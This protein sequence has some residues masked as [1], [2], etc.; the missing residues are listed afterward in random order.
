MKTSQID[1]GIANRFKE[2]RKKHVANNMNDASTLLSLAK[3]QISRVERG[4]EQLKVATINIM[5]KKFGLNREWLLDNVGNPIKKDSSKKTGLMTSIEMG[6]R[7]DKLTTE[8]LVLSKNLQKAW[9]I[10]ERHEKEIERQA[11]EIGRL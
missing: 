4:E 3:S 8:V 9:D 6:D 7:I 5:V 11:K 1:L 10:I 2:F